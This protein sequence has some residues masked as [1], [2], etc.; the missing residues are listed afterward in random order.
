V[1]LGD[2]ALTLLRREALGPATL[3]LIE[4]APRYAQG[5]GFRI[6]AATVADCADVEVAVAAKMG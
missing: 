2:R 6:P 5:T 1:V 4:Q 3:T